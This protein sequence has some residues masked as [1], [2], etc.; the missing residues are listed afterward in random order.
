M[1]GEDGIFAHAKWT[2]CT[3]GCVRHQVAE[4][5]EV[6]GHQLSSQDCQLESAGVSCQEGSWSR[7][8]V[9]ED[10]VQA[11]VVYSSSSLSALLPLFLAFPF[12]SLPLPLDSM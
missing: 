5:E 6:D 3:Q 10:A 12:E 11:D 7:Q 4:D 9:Y 2:T 8:P 1:D